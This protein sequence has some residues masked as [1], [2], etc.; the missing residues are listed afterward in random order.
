M[1]QRILVATDF[2][3]SADE[4]LRWAIDLARRLEADLCLA[5]VAMPIST[6]AP[7]NVVR[8]HERMAARAEA[9][10][11]ERA[12]AAALATGVETILRRGEPVHVLTEMARVGNIDLVVVGA[13]HHRAG[14]ILVGSV[15]ERLIRLAPC[16][17]VVVKSP[18]RRFNAAS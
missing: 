9:M 2:S 5:Y 17:V 3:P 1:I 7:R 16:P 8:D 13:Q 18:E 14:D 4:A 6:D 11:K 12:A 10:L 15:A